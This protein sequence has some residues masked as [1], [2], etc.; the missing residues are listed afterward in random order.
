MSGWC[1]QL[2][3]AVSIASDLR[4]REG[5]SIEDNVLNSL[6]KG[7]S[8]WIVRKSSFSSMI[9]GRNSP[10]FL[11]VSLDGKKEGW[12]FGGYLTIS[13]KKEFS[14][15]NSV[16]KNIWLRAMARDIFLDKARGSEAR[17]F[18]RK[19]W[20]NKFSFAPVLFPDLGYGQP[21]NDI[22]NDGTNDFIFNLEPGTESFAEPNGRDGFSFE[23]SGTR[24]NSSSRNLTSL[25]LTSYD[26]TI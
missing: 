9:D 8:V 24:N 2:E 11:V 23:A 26:L 14:L 21:P 19:Y 16:E 15:L 5:P 13:S 12:V 3:K 4:L 17:Y 7:Q 20:N 6:N 18:I 10:W 25:D 22:D 1:L